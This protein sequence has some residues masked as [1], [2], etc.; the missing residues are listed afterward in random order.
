MAPTASMPGGC[1][2]RAPYD[3]PIQSRVRDALRNGLLRYSGGHGW[4]G[5]IAR[6][7]MDSQWRSRFASSFKGIDYQDWRWPWSCR[8]IGGLRC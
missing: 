8:R 2:F 5:P 4:P 7:E 1:G 6:I 3:A